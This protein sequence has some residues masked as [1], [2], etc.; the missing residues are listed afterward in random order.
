MSTAPSRALCLCAAMLA[1]ALTGCAAQRLKAVAPPSAP[2]LVGRWTLDRAQ[3]EHVDAA[4]MSLETQLRGLLRR[5]RRAEQAQ[6]KREPTRRHGERNP[7]NPPAGGGE[8]TLHEPGVVVSAPLLGA[9]WVREFIGHVPVG[10]YLGVRLTPEAFSL[11]SAAGIQQCILGVPT[12]IAYGHGGANQMCGWEGHEFL[13]VA[14]PLLGPQLT[15]RF[16]LSPNGE[17]V[18][19]LHLT[20][21]GINVRLIRRYRRTPHA[22]PPVL[23]P[24]SD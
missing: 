2:K 3:S 13:I 21:H 1:A 7:T 22:A 24:T 14:K 20:G 12:A 17:L 19:T 4:V 8:P 11:H 23:L 9:S 10:S 16:A 5:A 6:R 18:L 15:E